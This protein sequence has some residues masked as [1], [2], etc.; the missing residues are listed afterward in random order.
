MNRLIIT[1]KGKRRFKLVEPFSRNGIDVPIGFVTDGASIPR[2]FWVAFAPHE[3]LTSAVIHDYGYTK[4]VTAYKIGDYKT[5]RSW[6]RRADAAF[7][8]ALK[9]DDRKVARLFYNAVR[10]WR[11]LRYRKAR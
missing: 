5:A 4:A 6:F 10:L 8:Q 1:P 9:E 3:Y 11:W 7:L 2:I